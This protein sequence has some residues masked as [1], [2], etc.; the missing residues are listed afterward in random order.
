MWYGDKGAPYM[1]DKEGAT[2]IYGIDTS[3]E[4]SQFLGLRDTAGRNPMAID[5]RVAPYNINQCP[6]VDNGSPQYWTMTKSS[7]GPDPTTAPYGTRYLWFWGCTTSANQGGMAYM[8]LASFIHPTGG[9]RTAGAGNTPPCGAFCYQEIRS[10]TTLS[11][12]QYSLAGCTVG[13]V[14]QFTDGSWL[15]ENRF[16]VRDTQGRSVKPAEMCTIAPPGSGWKYVE[17]RFSNAENAVIVGKKVQRVMVA[18]DNQY[19]PRLEPWRSY[20]DN[21]IL[22]LP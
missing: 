7:T 15:N 4:P 22:K 6:V 1:D 14:L 12:W 21:I 20:F 11:W 5:I 2:M 3:F 10:G 13:V 9:D 17:V 8:E 19:S 18:Y 16:D